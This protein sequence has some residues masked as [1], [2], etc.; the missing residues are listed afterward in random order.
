MGRA[1]SKKT[2]IIWVLT[3]GQEEGWLKPI[4]G[5]RSTFHWIGPRAGS[6][7]KSK[8]IQGEQKEKKI[9]KYKTVKKTLFQFVSEY[10]RKSWLYFYPGS[11]GA[12]IL[13]QW[14]RKRFNSRQKI[15]LSSPTLA[16]AYH[17][18]LHWKGGKNKNWFTFKPNHK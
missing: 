7:S 3:I 13:M 15:S 5:L 10:F 18:L 17:H 2:G 16:S 11:I 1:I 6:V 14:N 4:Q 9:W 12:T 8:A